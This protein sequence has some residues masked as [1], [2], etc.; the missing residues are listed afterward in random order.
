MSTASFMPPLNQVALSVIDLRRTERWYREGLGFLPAGGSRFMMSTPLAGRV[1]GVPGAASTCWWLVGRNPWFQIEMFQFRRPMARLMPLDARAC[2]I[3]YR[4]IGVHV[5]DFDATLH[6]LAALGAPPLTEALGERGRRRVCVRDPDGVFV[7]LM[8]DD[9]LPEA[10][11]SARADAPA[12]RSVTLSTLDLAATL[13]YL[14]A[15]AGRDPE[16]LAL[17]S[18]E[19][20]ALWRLPGA[21]CKRAI[22]R[23]GDV[24]AEVVQYLEPLA[25]PWPAGYRVCDQGILNIAFGA[26]SR[27]DHTRVF[28]RAIAF[29]ARPN[30]KPLHVPGSGVVYVNDPLGFSVEINWLK[31]GKADREWGFEPLPP[32]RRPAA[33]NQRVEDSIRIATRTS[34][35]WQVL[36]DQNAMNRWSGF[37]D[38]RRIRDG[39][40]DPNGHG[41]ERLMRGPT[42]S[43]V[44]QTTG[45][46]RDRSIRY[47]VVQGS[48]FVYHNGEIVLRAAGSQATEIEWSV[49]FR[50]RIPLLGGLFRVLVRRMLSQMLRTGLKPYVEGDR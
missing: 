39:A 13:A 4:R 2:D 44:E 46:E 37:S 20:E 22:F 26:R 18:P 21:R 30:C 42:G 23:C 5:F 35:V 36:T 48:P 10:P 27:A 33:D 19:H 38:V 14:K 50:S 29:G 49:R 25:W 40:G 1:Q 7:E 47:R 15:I 41:S 17:H 16:D 9:P 12:M 11:A 32:A 31:P 3:G 45:V 43:V 24:L 28:D 6:R 8:E 34:R